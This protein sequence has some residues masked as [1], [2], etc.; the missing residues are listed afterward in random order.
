[1][2]HHH[3]HHHHDASAVFSTDETLASFLNR[4]VAERIQIG[5]PVLD[6]TASFNRTD[7]VELCGPAATG[8]TEFLYAA[9]LP[10]VL[11]APNRHLVYLDLDYKFEPYRVSQMLHAMLEQEAHKRAP[12][13]AVAEAR[14]KQTQIE[15]NLEAEEQRRR[16]HEEV[17]MTLERLH[18]FSCTNSLQFLATLKVLATDFVP[19]LYERGGSLGAIVVDNISAYYDVMREI[20]TNQAGASRR[21]AGAQE[22]QH[23][24]VEAIVHSLTELRNMCDVPILVSRRTAREEYDDAANLIWNNFVVKRASLGCAVFRQQRRTADGPGHEP[25]T[26]DVSHVER[27]LRWVKGVTGATPGGVEFTI[28]P[29]LGVC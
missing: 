27:T 11:Q 18:V 25:R 29:A 28:H 8:K 24:V 15:R 14:K 5:V 6:Q 10:H 9:C 12:D 26:I 22:P 7:V 16:R 3:H 20:K 19:S 13:P 2:N 23:S 4:S 1:M 17:R 21:S